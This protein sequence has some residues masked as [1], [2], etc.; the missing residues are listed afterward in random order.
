MTLR[1]PRG[2]LGS[3]HVSA[4]GRGPGAHTAVPKNFW[5]LVT[6]QQFD[7]RDGL[8]VYA[9]PLRWFG[10][11]R[12]FA[13]VVGREFTP[14]GAAFALVGAVAVLARSR[15]LGIGL[16]A[17]GFLGVPFAFAY[18]LEADKDRYLLVALWTAALLAACG[19]AAATAGLGRLWRST[20]SIASFSSIGLASVLVALAGWDAWNAR[21]TVAVDRDL[22]ARRFIT[23]TERISTPDAIVVA[24]WIYATPLAYAA[25]V[26][27]SFGHRLIVTAEAATLRERMAAWSS[28]SC[29]VAVSDR[30]THRLPGL[31]VSVPLTDHAPF[32]FRVTAGD[33][34]CAYRKTR[35][36][37]FAVASRD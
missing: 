21:G 20:P 36:A 12:R 16:L 1:R 11:A 19:A 27:R 17:F 35:A 28:R 7:K 6:G 34:R 8:A 15:M 14:L 37:R 33:D 26:E 29:V 22:T 23:A 18:A 3:P 4:Q 32:L 30:R 24:P 25:Y 31:R 5:W 13:S 2:S 9:Q 10:D